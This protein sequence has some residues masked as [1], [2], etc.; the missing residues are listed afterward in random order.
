[1]PPSRSRNWSGSF[2]KKPKSFEPRATEGEKIMSDVFLIVEQHGG[3][4]KRSSLELLSEFR[5]QGVSPVCLVP[6][7]SSAEKTAGTLGKFGAEKAVFLV[8][9]RLREY[10][11]EGYT[12][13]VHAYLKDKSPEAV[14]TA[15]TAQGKDLLPRL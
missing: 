14:A 3:E 11:T 13:A 15:A 4:V 1:N 9:D 7:D 10:S 8:D 2:G 6:G 5:R 12:N